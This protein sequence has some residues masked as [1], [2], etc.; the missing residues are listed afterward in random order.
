MTVFIRACSYLIQAYSMNKTSGYYV[1]SHIT[2]ES[3]KK[4]R[5]YDFAIHLPEFCCPSLGYSDNIKK[6]EACETGR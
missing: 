5:D 1:R 2:R 4:V 3:E 6:G